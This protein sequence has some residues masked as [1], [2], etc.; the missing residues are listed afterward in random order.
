MICVTIINCPASWG[1]LFQIFIWCISYNSHYPATTLFASNLIEV[2]NSKFTVLLMQKTVMLGL[3][4]SEKYLLR[5]SLVGELL[6]RKYLKYFS[7]EAKITENYP[8]DSQS[9]LLANIANSYTTKSLPVP[10]SIFSGKL[11]LFTSVCLRLVKQKCQKMLS[12]FSF[13]NSYSS[14]SLLY[15]WSMSWLN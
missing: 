6:T 13:C 12:T 1:D 15:F 7:C 5:L 10:F 9:D 8:Q 14:I 4:S 2:L 11:L 3:L